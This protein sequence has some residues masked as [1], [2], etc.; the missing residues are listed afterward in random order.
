MEQVALP[1]VL[2][3]QEVYSD[4]FTKFLIALLEDY[5]FDAALKYARALS[6]EAEHDILLRPHAAEIYRQACL[7]IYEVE[8]RL[9]K[10]GREMALFC[11]DHGLTHESEATEAVVLNLES[12]GVVT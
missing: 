2:A 6:S 4:S 10:S 12:Q 5:D 3:E 7:Y 1:I 9:Y 8:A 11:A